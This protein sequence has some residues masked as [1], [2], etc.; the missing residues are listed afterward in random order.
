MRLL[1]SVL[2]K[3]NLKKGLREDSAVELAV[4]RGE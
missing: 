4:G 2:N 1:L 3:N